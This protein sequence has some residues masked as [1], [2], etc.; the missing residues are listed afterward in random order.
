MY[1]YNAKI[2]L[3]I[4]TMNNPKYFIALNNTALPTFVALRHFFCLKRFTIIYIMLNSKFI[5]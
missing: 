5:K 4:K 2:N 3:I 1:L